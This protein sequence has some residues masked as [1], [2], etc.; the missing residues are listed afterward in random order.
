MKST[1]FEILF[2]FSLKDVPEIR[3]S[4]LH[5]IEKIGDG[6]F[7][8]LWKAESLDSDNSRT[9][10]L[11][12][13]VK[14]DAAKGLM[15]DFLHEM[16][17]IAGLRH[18]NIIQLM[19]I[20][21]PG[22]NL[23]MGFESNDMCGLKQCLKMEDSEE[24]QPL[25]CNVL[26]DV[27]SQICSALEYLHSNQIIHKDLGTRNCLI[28]GDSVVKVTY[29]GLGPYLHPEDYFI[30]QTCYSLPVRWMSPEALRTR[31]FTKTNDVWS[32]SILLWELF[33]CVKMPYEG[34]TDTEAIKCITKGELLP[35]PKEC[36]ARVYSLM[37]ECW[38][39]IPSERLTFPE[40]RER[41]ESWNVQIS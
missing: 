24:S 12:K 1:H 7:G 15:N 37:K 22:E 27:A 3:E 10:L 2:S 5:Y 17:L 28:N 36:P 16:N 26:L 25:N 6:S 29:F 30:D 21:S 41:L 4:Q 9:S 32:F 11:I 35:C 18:I 38:N 13:R 8:Q 39:I 33:S 40:I 23:F 19:C 20:S 34:K 31:R 14:S